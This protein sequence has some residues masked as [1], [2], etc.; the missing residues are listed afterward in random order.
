M[1]HYSS[2]FLNS[3]SPKQNTT[4]SSHLIFFWPILIPKAFFASL[5]RRRLSEAKIA[6][7]TRMFLA[8]ITLSPVDRCTQQ[9]IFAA[10]R[11]MPR[12]C[13]RSV[14]CYYVMFVQKCHSIYNVQCDYKI[15]RRLKI[16]SHWRN[17]YGRKHVVSKPK[18]TKKVWFHTFLRLSDFT[19]RGAWKV[20][21]KIIIFPSSRAQS[22]AL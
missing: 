1:N 5:S 16:H 3:N 8:T 10:F 15:W 14:A 13:F 2:F 6:M 11:A 7:G 12:V 19:F 4:Y 22:L 18:G 17:E 20:L 21:K 9:I